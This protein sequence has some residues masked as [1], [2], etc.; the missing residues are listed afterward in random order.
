MEP[1]KQRMRLDKGTGIALCLLIGQLMPLNVFAQSSEA[2]MAPLPADMPNQTLTTEQDPVAILRLEE[3][4]ARPLSLNIPR[5]REVR[6]L[7]NLG[8]GT[9]TSKNETFSTM[10]GAGTYRQD[11][12]SGNGPVASLGLAYGITKNIYAK[13]EIGYSS[14]QIKTER[15]DDRLAAETYIDDRS[16]I[17]EPLVTVGTQFL[18]KSTRLFGELGVEI[19]AGERTREV[20]GTTGKKV[21]SNNLLGGPSAIPR[22]GVIQDFGPVL[23][24]TDVS[25]TVRGDRNLNMNTTYSGVAAGGVSQKSTQVGGNEVRANTGIEFKHLWNLGMS[26]GYLGIDSSDT[27]TQGTF[28][29]RHT[30]ETGF[31]IAETQMGIKLSRSFVLIPKVAYKANLKKERTFSDGTETSVYQSDLWNLSLGTRFAF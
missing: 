27:T 25:Y 9:G 21:T 24:M 12:L 2:I 13:A 26:V 10:R 22:L 3:R 28:D 4:T 30:D 16:G 19:P 14:L 20:S 11:S 29:V 31:L 8:Y 1:T 18:F 6:I 15:N 7:F 17:S 23:W 5:G